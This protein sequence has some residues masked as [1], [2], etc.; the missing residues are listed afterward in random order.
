VSSLIDYID[1][2]FIISDIE[3]D[4][5]VIDE[6]LI[7]H[8]L[9]PFSIRYQMKS[10]DKL[11]TFNDTYGQKTEQKQ[12]DN[13][14]KLILNGLP[15]I[16]FEDTKND[17]L[18]KISSK[19]LIKFFKNPSEFYYTNKFLLSSKFSELNSTINDR[20]NFEKDNLIEYSIIKNII[21]TEI[22]GDNLDWV[23][24]K[25]RS[26]GN[27]PYGKNSNLY[28]KQLEN[29]SVKL[30]EKLNKLEFI[31]LIQKKTFEIELKNKITITVNIDNFFEE[32]NRVIFWHTSNLKAKHKIEGLI[33]HLLININYEN[34]ETIYISE[35]GKEKDN[36]FA[37]KKISK[38]EAEEHLL[39]ILELYK[40]GLESPLVFFPNSSYE[41][42]TEKRKKGDSDK[43]FNSKAM[44]EL[45][46]KFGFPS[47]ITSSEYFDHFFSDSENFKQNHRDEFENNSS[48]IFEIF[49][50]LLSERIC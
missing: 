35:N 36:C 20:E 19:N 34:I 30:V 4:K 48:I 17:D 41:Y 29:K 49:Y 6:I 37:L 24:K 32:I 11:E 43:A 38:I 9:Q 31:I 2:S 25:I 5:K 13:N 21:E 7:E 1:N 18:I 50:E 40:N 28:L 8:P 23:E 42:F 3:V 46:F 33:T 12:L 26:E 10:E 14:N 45:Y 16:I 22:Q 47:E 39:K 15:K 27:L 44:T